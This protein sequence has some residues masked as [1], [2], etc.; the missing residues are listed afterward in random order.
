VTTE[1]S[2][3]VKSDGRATFVGVETA[4]GAEVNSS[5]F[6]TIITLPYSKIDLGVPR[7]GF[8]MADLDPKMDKNR[9]IIPDILLAPTAEDVLSGKDPVMERA[10]QLVKRP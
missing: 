8:H 5:G 3:R 4:G 10:L 7:L 6:F 9:G 2:S 1:F